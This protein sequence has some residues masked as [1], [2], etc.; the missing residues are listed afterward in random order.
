METIVFGIYNPHH[1][2]TEIVPLSSRN[3]ISS[4]YRLAQAFRNS[5]ST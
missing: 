4:V 5:M 3:G 1:Y 2:L